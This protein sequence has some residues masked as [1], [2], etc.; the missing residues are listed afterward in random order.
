MQAKL[1]EAGVDIMLGNDAAVQASIDGLIANFADNPELPE[2]LYMIAHKYYTQARVK[3]SESGGRPD[4]EDLRKSI[5]VRERIIQELPVSKIT[6]KAYYTVAICYSQEL[7]EYAKGIAYYQTV[8]DNWPHYKYAWHAQYFVGMYTRRLKES[9][10]MEAA[11]AD[12][13]IEKAY[14]AVVENYTH[15]KSAATA[16]M[17]LAEI[18]SRKGLFAKSAEYYEFYLDKKI[19]QGARG[20]ALNRAYTLAQRIEKEEGELD[21]AAGWYNLVLAFVHEGDPVAEKA[22]AGLARTLKAMEEE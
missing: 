8:V 13:L 14:K 3:G 10:L 1:E 6:P 17:E 9:G 16:A 11:E 4:K 15:S 2:T 7:G 21:I 12:P 5:A 19:S 18:Y 20:M 22:T